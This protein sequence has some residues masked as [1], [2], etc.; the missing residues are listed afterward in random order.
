MSKLVPRLCTWQNYLQMNRCPVEVL[1]WKLRC[2]CVL[3]DDQEMMQLFRRWWEIFTAACLFCLNLISE[4]IWTSIIVNRRVSSQKAVNAFSSSFPFL[5]FLVSIFFFL[6]NFFLSHYLLS[7]FISLFSFFHFSFLPYIHY[8]FVSFPTFFLQSLLFCLLCLSRIL[9]FLGSPFS[10]LPSSIF[11]SFFLFSFC[12]SFLPKAYLK[13]SVA[14][15]K[16]RVKGLGALIWLELNS[17]YAL[18]HVIKIHK[19]ILI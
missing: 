12:L 6:S 5:S 15:L 7:V 3:L 17:S 14:S 19:C 18:T 4:G 1:T 2:V 9:S 10:L 13:Y 8:F 16:A 11:P